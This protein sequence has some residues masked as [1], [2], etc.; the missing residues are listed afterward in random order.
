M[1]T[2]C[3]QKPSENYLGRIFTT[4]LVA[5]PGVK[6]IDGRNFGPVIDA[7]LN[8]PGFLNDEPEKFITVGFSR[9]AVLS[10]ADKIVAAVKAGKIKHFFLIGGCDGVKSGRSYFTELAQKIPNDCIILTLACGKYRFNKREFGTIEGI[11]GL[12]DVGQCNDAYSAVKI[13]LALADVFKTDINHLP[14]SLILSWYEQKAVC[15]LLSLLFLGIK[16]IRIGPSMPAFI[17]PSVYDML[18]KNFN[19]MPV[20]TPKEDLKAILG[21]VAVV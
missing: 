18:K 14:L 7:A 4:G 21:E 5:W 13:A 8:S 19:L 1:T 3:I 6:H 2:N 9:N 16:N 12:L 11:P 15:I 17:T 10:V 20:T